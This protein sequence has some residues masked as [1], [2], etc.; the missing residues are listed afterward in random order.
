MLAATLTSMPAARQTRQVGVLGAFFYLLRETRVYIPVILATG[1]ALGA[2][3]ASGI[4]LVPLLVLAVL[5]GALV[6]WDV[7]LAASGTILLWCL[8]R[9]QVHWRDREADPADDA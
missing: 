4:L 6:I 8:R 7:L 5:L 2:Y 1:A 3:F 9:W